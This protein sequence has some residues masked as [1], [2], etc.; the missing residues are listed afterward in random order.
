MN[1]KRT[2][3]SILAL[4]LSAFAVSCGGDDDSSKHIETQL[5]NYAANDIV[6]SYRVMNWAWGNAFFGGNGESWF[7]VTGD[8]K[9]RAYS[10][11]APAQ[12]EDNFCWYSWSDVVEGQLSEADC[13]ALVDDLS[14]G[15][16]CASY[17][18][19]GLVDGDTLI[20]T[21]GEE[22]LSCYPSS[23]EMA[24][25]GKHALAVEDKAYAALQK[26]LADGTPVQGK[27][28]GYLL[29]VTREDKSTFL[30]FPE[31][32]R[33]LPEGMERLATQSMNDAAILPD[34]FQDAAKSLRDSVLNNTTP[35]FQCGIPLKNA[36]GDKFLLYLKP[37][38]D[39]ET[40]A[41]GIPYPKLGC[42]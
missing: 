2:L 19:K 34:E 42:D 6:L 18:E 20:I 1:A 24:G 23:C 25:A 11:V 36:D 22:E 33:V 39:I 14:I 21:N 4:S 8:C 29:S 12:A 30:N 31:H 16:V 3:A 27:L 28:R 38:A 40:E 9:Y 5:G 15:K 26:F 13:K 35:L 10:S 37:V 41:G 17:E 32:T 7:V